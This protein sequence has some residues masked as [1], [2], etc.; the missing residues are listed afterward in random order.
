MEVGHGNVMA[1]PH[2][3]TKV[4]FSSTGH[5][6]IVAFQRDPDPPTYIAIVTGEDGDDAVATIKDGDYDAIYY[7]KH[8]VG[9][10]TYD[11]KVLVLR[12]D[13]VDFAR[14]STVHEFYEVLSKP[15]AGSL[16][17]TGPVCWFQFFPQKHKDPYHYAPEDSNEERNFIPD[18]LKEVRTS[19]YGR[20][21][22]IAQISTEEDSESISSEDPYVNVEFSSIA[23]S[24]RGH[25]ETD[26]ELESVIPDG[27]PPSTIFGSGDEI[28]RELGSE[29]SQR[30]STSPKM[31]PLS[32]VSSVLSTTELRDDL[33]IR[34]DTAADRKET[35]G[36]EEDEAADS[37]SSE[38][39]RLT[40]RLRRAEAAL[41]GRELEIER[42]DLEIARLQSILMKYGV[43][44]LH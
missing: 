6:P 2:T 25:T 28:S 8:G 35:S 12:H 19:G 36:V 40:E 38:L 4:P 11:F 39:E 44:S 23:G 41:V 29:A 10:S 33:E 13:P 34:E 14:T 16:D 22:L 5:F 15:R 27:P 1:I 42:K 21:D 30:E 3:N 17:N 26:D 20:G 31:S 7:D 24:F 43:I 9:H 18:L 37:H 32:S